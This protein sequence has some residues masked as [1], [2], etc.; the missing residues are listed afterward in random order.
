MRV[1]TDSIHK[2]YRLLCAL[3]LLGGTAMY[4]VFSLNPVVWADEAYTFATIRHSFPE[5]WAITAADVHPPLYYILLKLLAAPFGYPLYWCRALSTLPCLIV[6][7]VTL[8]QFPRLF[9]EPTA[10]LFALLYLAFPFTMTY[11]AEVRMYSLAELFIFLNA[12]YAYRC[13]KWNRGRDWAV[14]ALSG[15]CAA[16]T[17]YF[18]LVS[19]GVLYLIGLVCAIRDRRLWKGCL[20]A[21][22]ATVVLYLPWLGSFLSQLAYKVNNEYWIEPIT[23]AV[24]AGYFKTIFHANGLRGFYRLAG[25]AYLIAFACL[26]WSKD[27][28]GIVLCLCALAVPVGTLV[29][30]LAASILVRPV[31]VVRYLLPSIPL[32]VFFFAYSLGK[33]KPAWLMAGLLAVSVLGGAAN[34]AYTVKYTLFPP[35]DRI[36]AERMQSLPACDA[37]VVLSGNTMHTSQVVAN[38]ALSSPVFTPD[39]LGADNP[40]PNR[41][42]LSEFR[43]E[44]YPRILLITQSDAGTPEFPPYENPELVASVAVSGTGQEFWY[45]TTT[46]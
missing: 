11:A 26:L 15:V 38:Y 10:I 45:L 44:D 8:R 14:F 17:H 24:V 32:A 20:L 16:Y 1:L 42:P 6:V 22:L 3:L 9:G 37:Y 35:S 46:E 23:G 31:F 36:T 33:M 41:L 27:R 7:A 43:A 25:L 34:G 12:L 30:G 39:T 40:Y 5:L 13:Q 28:R 19:A 4:A 2:H 18:A 21:A 29:I